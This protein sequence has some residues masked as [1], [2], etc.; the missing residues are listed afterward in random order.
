LEKKKLRKEWDL[1]RRGRGE[2]SLNKGK[3]NRIVVSSGA[4]YSRSLTRKRGAQKSRRG[5][6]EK[7][8]D[9]HSGRTW[10]GAG[11]EKRQ[12]SGN[13]RLGR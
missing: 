6:V 9:D 12:G 3:K 2:L 5:K 4:V 1:H 8:S 11:G 10:R 7:G 13:A